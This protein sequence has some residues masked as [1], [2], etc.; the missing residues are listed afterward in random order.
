[1][2]LRHEKNH[3]KTSL[4]WKNRVAGFARATRTATRWPLF[5]LASGAPA[6][7][8]FTPAQHDIGQN[9]P[10]TGRRR[11]NRSLASALLTMFALIIGLSDAMAYNR[12]FPLF[13]RNETAQP[14]TFTIE[15]GSCYQGTG[16]GF[17]EGELINGL[18]HGP[19]RPGESIRLIMAREQNSGCDGEGGNFNLRSSGYG[20]VQRFVFSNDGRLGMLNFPNHYTVAMTSNVVGNAISYTWTMSAAETRLASPVDERLTKPRSYIAADTGTWSPPNGTAGVQFDELV[21]TN[22]PGLSGNYY[23]S[24]AGKELFHPQHVVRLPNKDGRAYFMVA[25]SRAHNGWITLLQTAPDQIDPATDLL[26]TRGPGVRPGKYIWE[27]LYTGSFNGNFNPV[28]NWNH[29]GKMELIGGVLVVAAQ[30]WAESVP[31]VNYAQGDSEDAVLFYDVRDPEYPRYW[32]AMT[33]TQLGIT[34]EGFNLFNG[35]FE[36]RGGEIAGVSIVRSTTSDTWILRAGGKNGNKTWKTSRLSPNIEDWTDISYATFP[37]GQHGMNFN[38]YQTTTPASKY[39]GGLLLRPNGVERNIYF[40]NVHGLVIVDIHQYRFEEKHVFVFEEFN[41]NQIELPII[42]RISG[43]TMPVAVRHDWGSWPGAERDWDA[44]SVYVTRKGVPV[45]YTMRSAEGQDGLLYQVHDNQNAALQTPHPDQT[46]THTRDE[47]VGS[48]RRAIGYGGRITFDPSLD[49]QTITLANGPLIVSLYDVN[50]DASALP[51]GIT[52]SGSLLPLPTLSLL[53]RKG[54]VPVIR[55]TPGNSLTMSGIKTSSDPFSDAV[56]ETKT[57]PY[58]THLSRALPFATGGSGNWFAQRGTTRDGVQAAQSGAITNSQETYLQ[59][60]VT[61]PGTLTFWWKV[62]SEVKGDFLRFTLD[63]VEQ[64]GAPPISGTVDWQKGTIPIPAG[65]HQLRWNYVKNGAVSSGAD[66]GYV[67]QVA[68]APLPPVITSRLTASGTQGLS[69][70]SGAASEY[71]ITATGEPFSYNATG[72]PAGLFVNPAT[73]QI[74]SSPSVSGTFPVTIIAYNE[75]GIGTATLTITIAPSPLSAFAAL[76][77]PNQP[78]GNASIE[79]NFFG[80]TTTTHDGVDAM[81]SSSASGFLATTFDGPGTFTFWWKGQLRLRNQFGGGNLLSISDDVNW[82]K[83][84]VVIPD[85]DQ[86]TRGDGYRVSWAGSG[87]IDEVVFVPSLRQALDTPRIPWTTSG[88]AG[89][90]GQMTT[91]HSVVFDPER[92]EPNQRDAAQSGVIGNLGRSI[93]DTTV[94]GPATLT[95]WW[96]VSSQSASDY[97]RFYLDGVEQPGAPAISGDVDWQQ[98]TIPIPGGNHQLRWIYSKNV[99]GSGG[100]DASWVDQVLLTPGNPITSPLTAVATQGRPFSY[101]IT[102]PNSPR[103]YDAYLEPLFLP[104]PGLNVAYDTG[105]ISG[106]PTGSGSFNLTLWNNSTWGTNSVTLALTILPSP[107]DQTAAA[108]NASHLTWTSGGDGTW[109]GQA[110]TTHDS[111]SAAQSGGIVDNLLGAQETHLS[112]MVTGP[113]MLTFWWKVSSEERFDFLRFTLDGIQQAGAPEISGE[114]DWRQQTIAVPEGSHTLSW[115]YSKDEAPRSNVGTDAGWVDEVVFTPGLLA[116]TEATKN[117]TLLSVQFDLDFNV[118]FTGWVTTT[119]DSGPG[120]LRQVIANLPADATVIFDPSLSGQ[121]ITLVSSGL[122][123][124]KNLTIDASGLPEG[125]TISG[126]GALGIFT[127]NAG[128]SLTL[129]RLTLSKGRASGRGGAI[130]A[131][132]NSVLSLDRCT[133]VG[134]DAAEGG[135]IFSLGSLSLSQCTLTGNTSSYGGAIQCQGLTSITRCTITGN[136]AYAGGGIFN[137]NTTLSVD[138]SIVAGNSAG[139]GGGPDIFNENALLEYSGANVVQSVA[140]SGT[141]RVAGPA[142]INAAP[143]LAPLGRYGGPTQTMPPLGGSPALDAGGTTSLITDQ[144]GL[145]RL[146]GSAVDIGAVEAN[147]DLAGLVP[148]AGTL[149]PAFASETTAYTLSVSGDTT[150]VTFTPAK[151]QPDSTIRVNGFTV[152]SGAASSAISLSVGSNPITIAVTAQDGTTVKNYVVTVTRAAPVILPSSNADLANL[153]P[154]AGALTP[155][156]GSAVT[157]YTV[158]VPNAT[159][160]MTFLPTAAQANATVRVNGATTVS[161]TASSAINLAVGSNPVAIAVTAQDGITV[162]NYAVTVTRAGG[163]TPPEEGTPGLNRRFHRARPGVTVS[164][165]YPAPRGKGIFPAGAAAVGTAPTQS[166]T[167]AK[168]EAPSDVGEEYGQILHGY[169]VPSETANYTFYLCSDD[170]G[171]LWLSTD[172]N[173]ANS[174]LIASEPEYNPARTWNSADRRPVAN[175]LRANISPSIRLEAGKYYYVEAVMKEGTGGDNLGVAWTRAGAPMPANG[176]EPIPGANL[177]TRYQPG[178]VVSSNADLANLV[179]SA[180]SLTPGFGSAVTGYTVSVPNAIGSMTL[181]PTAAQ[182][183]ATIKVNGANTTSGAASGAINLA[184]GSNA[185]TL[186]VTAQDGT[187]VKN[188]VVTVTRAAPVILPSSNADLAN[189]VLSAGSLTPGF[190]SAVTAY[191][192]SVPNATGS[193]TVTPT[194]AQANATIKVNGVTVTSGAAS[195]AI[196]LA[197]GSNPVTI[198]VTAQDGSTVKNYVVTVTRSTA[199]VEGTPGLNRL[200]YRARPGVTLA[201]FYFGPRG[202]GVFPAGAAPVGTG[203]TQSGTVAKFEAPSN[204]GDEYGQILHGYVVPSETANYTFYLCSDDQG[205]LWLSTDETPLNSRLI[206]SEP[207]YSDPARTWNSAARRPVANGRRANVSASIRLEAGKYYYVEAVMKEGNGGDNLGVAWTRAGAPM[208]ANGSEPIPGANLRTRFQ[209]GTVVSSNADLANLVPSAGTLTPGFGSAVTAYTVSVPNAT[210][211]MT[212]I[213]TAAQANATVRVNGANTISGSASSAINLAVGSNAITIAVTAQDGTTVKTYVVTVLRAGVVPTTKGYAQLVRDHGAV[214]YWRLGEST[215][216]I[217]RDEIGA[218]NGVLLHGVTLGV[219]GALAIDSNTAARFRRETQQKIDVTWSA[220]LNPPQF[221]AEVW[222]RVS[223]SIADH[224]SPLTSRAEGPERGYIFYAEPGNTWQFWTGKGDFSGWD[225]IPGP[226]VE[227]EK[228][229]HL[230]AT[231][232]GTTKRFFVNGIEVGSSTAAFGP[233]DENPL[234]FGGGGTEGD[235]N[236]FFEGDVDE[237][238]IYNKALTREQ[239]LQHYLT[240]VEGTAPTAELSIRYDRGQIVIL[241]SGTLHSANQVGGPYSVVSGAKSPFT[242]TPDPSAKFYVVR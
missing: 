48:L 113:G 227:P 186:A 36:E 9:S 109:F 100:D 188:Y 40:D 189:L 203:S 110:T 59:S 229:T 19:V 169:V 173:P 192:V 13:L 10:S 27:D 149:S 33:A 215:G 239:I 12:I 107:M 18:I 23:D 62:S 67:D 234:R 231:Y 66:A 148:S 72:L 214:G 102:S 54:V 39:P 219:A 106:T 174:R 138:Y 88:D 139:G 202:K 170:Q 226:A 171:E 204:I 21:F 60:A 126:G 216:E 156:F 76:D 47:G 168:F 22:S 118:I 198:A 127:V 154:S 56:S 46:V 43:F 184:V 30:N 220:T 123:I 84:T 232:D 209:P 142:S 31:S 77:F 50:I 207:E 108:L 11:I 93:L 82:R 103:E 136:E 134:H 92:T 81:Q 223:G 37:F 2:R 217:A 157:A 130:H 218:K 230:V 96:K 99:S 190:G 80:Q 143:L 240:G 129:S 45:V 199:P 147:A 57:R 180:G 17:F 162:K 140:S 241:Y 61:G 35:V 197:V 176:S 95:F 212:F 111:V 75:G 98:K 153:V 69:F 206:A 58:N 187:T 193:M 78:V 128:T 3:M 29:P 26:I 146:F 161:G 7:P 20:E 73:G 213:P 196:T 160:S 164:N 211:S 224:R 41:F 5:G 87:F 117:D 181:I 79:G 179:P 236:Y 185:I 237:P 1:M 222:A 120:S 242:V 42:G 104:P 70:P 44:D 24:A 74:S 175:G 49:G 114:V 221:S 112:T 208:P 68:F 155:G 101:Q 201:A 53:N 14:V 151:A 122:T 228:W 63:G 86:G 32:G 194:A 90:F 16:V 182:A 152:T 238:A 158:S 144:R 137:K 85:D 183:N 121:T 178:T 105:L 115:T 116:Y 172:E 91:T 225:V 145:P 233:N 51:Q 38:S 131:E 8:S 89:W 150:S 25:Q 235:G 52:I 205:E 159:G 65:S 166:G 71:F 133:L 167:V 200:F 28:G 165:F 34:F 191:T 163:V 15:P 94:T 132:G 210:A 124:G 195:S 141:G 135:A 119:N 64:A 4:N 6:R 125:I 97:L 55:V 177:R 83:E